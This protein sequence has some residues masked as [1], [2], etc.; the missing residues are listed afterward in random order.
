MT[1]IYLPAFDRGY[2][3]EI[4]VR[5][6]QFPPFRLCSMLCI[7]LTLVFAGASMTSIV[8]RLQHDVGVA[9]D[10]EHLPLSVIA[11]DTSDHADG[12][13]D[14]TSPVNSE[15][16]PS[17]QPGTEH[18]H[19]GDSGPSLAAFGTLGQAGVFPISSS[20]PFVGDDRLASVL[21]HGPERPPKTIANRT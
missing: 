2:K 11:F 17:H 9:A 7:A 4:V 6:L 1:S 5:L 8:D 15:D 14:A 12:H 21:I 16:A 18:H 3:S 20:Q 10:H 13:S 19:H